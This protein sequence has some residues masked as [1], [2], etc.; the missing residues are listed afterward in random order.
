MSPTRPLLLTRRRTLSA[1]ALAGVSVFAV[2]ALAWVYL[3]S[4]REAV[5]PTSPD[6]ADPTGTSSGMGLIVTPR[7]PNA[8]PSPHGGLTPSQTRERLFRHGSL[9][10]TTPTGDW[11]VRG[12]RLQPCEALRHRFEYYL[13]AQGEVEAADLRAL[14][15]DELTRA[16][17]PAPVAEV[18]ALWDR[19][20][21]LRAH[22][23]RTVFDPRNLTTWRAL[24]D[25]QQRTRRQIL[26][27]PWAQA[28]FAA[29]EAEARSDLA[30]LE[31]GTALPADPGLPVPSTSQDASADITRAVH[32]E[33]VARYGAAA[34]DRL[35]QAD[36]QWADWSRRLQ[37]AQ[38]EWARLQAAAE[39]SPPQ[40]RQAI[41]SHIQV[42]FHPD[43]RRRVAALLAL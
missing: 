40:R 7:H 3:G 24:L 31:R 10:G 35:T 15:A 12:T 28:F 1:W 27:D 36:A 39:L 2:L 25:E 4:A 11:C 9:S 8:E 34:A 43:E 22:P 6:R 14:V 30:H 13:L 32:S 33:R 26:G 21:T 16:H 5:S 37:T 38:S 19:Y 29:E 41:D 18:L 23:Y 42:H 20:A 17:G